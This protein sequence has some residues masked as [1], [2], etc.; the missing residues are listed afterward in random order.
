MP[1]AWNVIWCS[2]FNHKWEKVTT[3][4]EHET[5]TTYWVCQRCGEEYQRSE[6]DC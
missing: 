1:K 5:R 6:P 2:V 4:V 3:S